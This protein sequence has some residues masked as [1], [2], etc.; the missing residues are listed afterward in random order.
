[1]PEAVAARGRR[2]G[3]SKG[4]EREAAIL[5]TMASLLAGGRALAAVGIDDLAQGAG[6]TRSSFYFYFDSREAALRALAARVADR[7]L[8]SSHRWLRRD[9]EEPYDALRRAGAAYLEL[10]RDEGPVLRAISAASATDPELSAFWNEARR[11]FVEAAAEQ[12][13]RDRDAGVALAGPP[14]AMDLAGVLSAM[15]ERVCSAATATKLS[16][17]GGE[18]VIDALATVWHRSIYGT[19]TT[20]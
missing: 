2:R 16:A 4:D 1:V 18:R 15:S 12:I 11:Q 8:E 5:D 3:P 6:I 10:W 13:R 7:V 9:E 20:A 17:K 19:A 14:E